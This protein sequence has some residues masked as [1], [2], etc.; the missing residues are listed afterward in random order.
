VAIPDGAS[1]PEFRL[2]DQYGGQLSLAELCAEGPVLLVFFP[3]AFSGVCS[4]ELL[5]L[6]DHLGEFTDHGVQVAAISCDPMFTLRA[7]DDANGFDFPL[8]SDFWPHGEVCRRYAAF[9]EASGRAERLSV[10]IDAAGVV[11]WTM[12][13][14]VTTARPLVA[15]REALQGL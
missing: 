15:Y 2:S 1:A 14:P 4:G 9:D 11:R 10:L 3:F 8:L 7:W 13:T 5:E 12:M 6:R